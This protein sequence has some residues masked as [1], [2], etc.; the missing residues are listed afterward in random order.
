MGKNAPYFLFYC[1]PYFTVFLGSD[2]GRQVYLGRDGE[3]NSR[4]IV[5]MQHL[6]LH[7]RKLRDYAV[8]LPPLPGEV[9][10]KARSGSR[11]FLCGDTGVRK[12]I[13]NVPCPTPLLTPAKNT[14][15]SCGNSDGVF[16]G[17]PPQEPEGGRAGDTIESTGRSRLKMFWRTPGFTK[18]S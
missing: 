3:K 17:F 8:L 18:F 1:F 16:P 4:S 15:I 9:T 7:L 13:H 10:S 14:T 6:C 2:R 11:I 12:K 5:R